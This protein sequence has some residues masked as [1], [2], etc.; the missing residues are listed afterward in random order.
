MILI[1][2]SLE[3]G[4]A[5]QLKLESSFNSEGRSKYMSVNSEIHDLSV[6][7]S[8]SSFALAS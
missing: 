1:I 7:A 2:S 6:K 4:L 8:Q 5:N 3:M